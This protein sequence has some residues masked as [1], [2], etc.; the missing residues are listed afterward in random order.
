M[1]IDMKYGYLR[2]Y[3]QKKLYVKVSKYE[4]WQVRNKLFG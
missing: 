4:F 3:P 2:F 1:I